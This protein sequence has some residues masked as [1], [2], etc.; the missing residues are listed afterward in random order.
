MDVSELIEQNKNCIPNKISFIGKSKKQ[1]NDISKTY[2]EI[3][4]KYDIEYK[5]LESLV[6]K[7]KK[8]DNSYPRFI[9]NNLKLFKNYI[10]LLN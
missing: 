10:E 8:I 4:K 6:T 5:E 1:N 9:F 7:V 3:L 2:L